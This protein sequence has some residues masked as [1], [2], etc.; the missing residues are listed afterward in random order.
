MAENVDMASWDGYAHLRAMLERWGPHAPMLELM[1]IEIADLEPGRIV[2][3][4]KP[5]ERHRPQRPLLE[6]TDARDR[7]RRM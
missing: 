4:N 7:G 5:D 3:R 2:V 1:G 6:S